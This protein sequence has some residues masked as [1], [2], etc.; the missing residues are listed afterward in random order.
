M[1]TTT[2]TDDLQAL[3]EHL[4]GI[5]FT[6]FTTRDGERLRSRPM[7]TIE[8]KDGGETLLFLGNHGS[9]LLAD[10]ARDPHVN[11]AY[12]D[13]G[14]A[15]Y[16][17]VSGTATSRDDRAT[18]K[19]IWNPILKAWWDGPEDPAIR[20]IEIRIQTAEYW[21]GPSSRLVRL[22]GVA[23]AAVTGDEYDDGEH[24]TIE[25]GPGAR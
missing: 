12:S 21:A 16:V 5:R 15:K 17:S 9:E 11:L 10:I 23:A 19:E 8:S 20:V 22:V 14:D 3:H 13:E 1:A 25:L 6:M 7:T 18:I 4:E 2:T 24:G